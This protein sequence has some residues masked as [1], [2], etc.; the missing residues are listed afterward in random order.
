MNH[1]SDPD[2]HAYVAGA[3]EPPRALEVTE[4][5]AADP[6]LGLRLEAVQAALAQ[7]PADRGEWRIP[8]PGVGLRLMLSA[9]AAPVMGDTIRPGDRFRVRVDRTDDP[10]RRIRVLFRAGQRW[11]VMFPAG[12]DEELTVAELPT[13]ESGKRHLDLVAQPPL[14]AQRWAVALCDPSET[15]DWSAAEGPRWAALRVGIT[16]GQVPVAAVEVE[17]E[18]R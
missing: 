12:P 17:V 13:D 5:V 9:S 10:K 14:G 4:A 11:Q 8:P 6:Q 18:R 1:V 3:L 16:A 2:L 7:G 15:V